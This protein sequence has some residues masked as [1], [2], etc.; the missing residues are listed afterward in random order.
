MEKAGERWL[1]PFMDFVD[2]FRRERD[3]RLVEDPFEHAGERFDA[4]L[5]STIEYL[6]DEQGFEPPVWSWETPSCREPWLVA[7]LESIKAIALV[8][9]PAHFRVR[10]IFVLENFLARV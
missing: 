2:D 7:G 8:E 9:N 10:E 5:A 3:T 1:I 6:C 4:L